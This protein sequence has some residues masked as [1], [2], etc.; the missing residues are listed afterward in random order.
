VPAEQGGRGSAE[1]AAVCSADAG[2]TERLLLLPRRGGLC[3]R[4]RPRFWSPAE[5]SARRWP[6][7]PDWLQKAQGQSRVQRFWMRVSV[8][9]LPRTDKPPETEEL[10]REKGLSAGLRPL[11]IFFPYVPHSDGE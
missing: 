5:L 8:L 1:R 10:G 9:L 7:D 6:G 11:Q 3:A 2:T 4:R